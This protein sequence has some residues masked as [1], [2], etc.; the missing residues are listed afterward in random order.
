[1]Y[2]QYDEEQH[3]LAICESIK[4]HRRFLDIGAWS[5]K[6]FS[7][8]RALFE[9]GWGG[10][11]IEPS[12]GP[13]K[14]LVREYGECENIEVIAAALTIEGVSV[15]LVVTDDAVSQPTDDPKRVAQWS[16]TAGFYGRLTVPSIS[17]KQFF[18]QWGGDFEMM[19]IDTEGTS[20]DVFAEIVRAGP[21][22]RCIVVEH[23]SRYVEVAGIAEKAHY[24]Q[25]HLNGT[26]C[27]LEWTGKREW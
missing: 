23:D 9:L 1:M 12:P 8:T 18:A 19:S 4:N 17:V 10:V 2:S 20:V 6:T 5:A 14:E 27:V 26:N 24:R 25:V 15:R 16:G 7:N 21:R 11:L 13:V 3:V 22:P